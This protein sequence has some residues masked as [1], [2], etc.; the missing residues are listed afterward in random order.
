MVKLLAGRKFRIFAGLFAAYLAFSWFAVDP[1]ARRLLPWIAESSL[2][3]RLE[4]ERVE[5][6][7]LR[8]ILRV[9]NLRL[10][11]MDG[12]PLAGFEH[13]LVDMEVSGIFRWAWRFGDIRLIAPQAVLEVAPGGRLNWADLLAKLNE[14]EPREERST[15]ARVLVDHLLIERGHI[16]YEDHDRSTPFRAVLQPL[17]L[18]LGGLSTLPQDRGDYAILARLPEQGGTLRWKGELG[19]NPLMSSGEVQVEGIQLASLAQIVHTEANPVTVTG[20]DLGTKFNYRFA[21]VKGDAEPY[22]HVQVGN[23]DVTLDRVAAELT[24]AAGGTS[25]MALEQLSLQLPALTFSKPADVQL[26]FDDLALNL[27]QLALNHQ[28]ETLFGLDDAQVSGVGFDLTDNRLQVGDVL[29]K[30][31]AINARRGK[32]GALDWL[33][34]AA[35]FTGN[36]QETPEDAADAQE[37]STTPMSLAVR[38]V[39]L[40]QWRASYQDETFQHPLRLEVDGIAVGFA[41]DNPEGVV[42]I[43]ELNSRIEGL[44]LKSS[45]Y[46]KPVAR[47]ESIDLKNGHISLKDTVFNLA[48]LVFSGLKADVLQDAGKPLNWQAVLTPLPSTGKTVPARESGGRQDWKFGIDRLALEKVAVYFEDR[49][50]AMPATV[51]IQNASLELRQLTQ[52]LAKSLPV[53]ARLPVRQ[54]GLLE[55]GGKLALQPMN[56]DLQVKLQDVALRTFSPYVNQAALL[57]LDDGAL[58]LQGRLALDLAKSLKGRFQGSFAIRQ[59]AV[60]EEVTGAPFLTWKEVASDTLNLH[61]APARLHVDELR[62]VQPAGKFI[63]HEDGTMN[64]KQILRTQ[65]ADGGDATAT[66]TDADG[67]G[68]QV[69]VER[70]RITDADLEFADLTLTPQF[71]THINSLSGVINGLSSDPA[72]TAQVELDGK[73]DEFGS[74]RIRGTVQPFQATDFTDLKLTFRNLEMNRLTPYSGKFAGRRIDSGKLSVDLEYKIKQRQ[75][76]GENKFLIDKIKLG[77]RVDSPDAMNLPLDLAIALLEDSNGIIDLDLPI[78]GSLDDPQFSYGKIIWKAVVN[79]LTKIVTSPFRALANLMGLSSETMQDIGFEPGKSDLAPQEQEKLKAIADAMSKRPALVLTLLPSFDP[80]ADRAALQ[81]QA[82]RHDVLQEMGIR[83]EAG[84]QPGPVDLGNPKAQSA[85]ERLLKSRTGGGGSLRAVDAVKDYFRKTKP[86][87]LPIYAEK[88][89]QLKATVDVP[90]DQ[91][92]QLALARAGAMRDYLVKSSGLD[93]GRVAIGDAVAVKSDGSQVNLRM[94]LGVGGVKAVETPAPDASPV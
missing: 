27:R 78:S 17:G 35:A 26:N 12:V 9:D 8:L 84:E 3:S 33:R 22:P 16:R 48:E 94:E 87:D 70:V 5:F 28:D 19:L 67:E 24:D 37:E 54:G 52:D 91:L 32:D 30:G 20:G 58:R 65:D 2:A 41:A 56:A 45:L 53:R 81:E 73:V 11:N 43:R 62:I 92:R 14:G 72:T 66:A 40:E 21:L 23:L 34:L 88:L 13:L 1:L 60:S 90:E 42:E 86:E 7:P 61:L 31:G 76:T 49:T 29:L 69:A 36:A 4:V 47:L 80:A 82:T 38:H 85:I 46:P 59:L 57:K 10:S 79:V 18:E 50:T 51:D 6:D 25:S 39:Q 55:V 68:F 15:I 83:L 74:A 71:G 77:E 93:A 63:I 44:Q 75:L 64:V 89:E